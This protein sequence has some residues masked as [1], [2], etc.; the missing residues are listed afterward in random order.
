M[1]NISTKQHTSEELLH[2]QRSNKKKNYKTLW[3]TKAALR[4]NFVFLKK[5]PKVNKQV[6]YNLTLKKLEK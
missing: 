1:S 6:S 5:Q 2:Q 4:E 3:D